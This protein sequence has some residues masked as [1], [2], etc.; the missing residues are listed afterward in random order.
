VAIGAAESLVPTFLSFACLTVAWLLV[1]A[2]MARVRH[3]PSAQRSAFVPPR[4]AGVRTRSTRTRSPVSNTVRDLGQLHGLESVVQQ[5]A[6]DRH[7]QPVAQ[8]GDTIVS[9]ARA[10]DPSTA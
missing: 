2:G 9:E 1:A 4:D 6:A 7:D 10:S 3:E 8:R 5:R